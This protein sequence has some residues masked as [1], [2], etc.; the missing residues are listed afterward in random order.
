MVN[1]TLHPE[2]KYSLKEKILK[3]LIE[4]KKE[5]TILEISNKL[6]EDYKN[7]FQA[8]NSLYPEYLIKEKKGNSNF[9]QINSKINPLIYNIEEK[10]TKEFLIANKSINLLK[11]DIISLNYPFFIFLVFGSFAKKVNTAH[12]DLDLC[13]ISDEKNNEKT[14]EIISKIRLLPLSIEIHEFT[15]SQFVSMLNKKEQNLGKEIVKNNIILYGIE[16]YYRII[17]KWMNKE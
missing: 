2:V 5:H 1:N 6:K 13:L 12:S 9:I 14:K 16:N 4:D 8:I 3:L 15:P 10:R 11:E 7:T 17:S